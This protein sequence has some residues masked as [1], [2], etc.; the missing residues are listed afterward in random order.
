[1]LKRVIE[2][3][4]ISEHP[5]RYF[6]ARVLHFE[7]IDSTSAFLKEQAQYANQQSSQ[8]MGL[9]ALAEEQTA[10]YGRMGRHWHSP[11]GEGFYFSMLLTPPLV[12]NNA[13][14]L[15]LMAAVASA[16]AIVATGARALDIKWPNDILIGKRKIAGIIAEAS[17]EEQQ[18]NY[19]VLGIGV[20]LNQK[21]FPA[22]LDRRATSLYL[23]I[24]KRIEPAQFLAELLARIDH[25]YGVLISAPAGIAERWQHLSSFAQ[26]R[27]IQVEHQGQ[28]ICART[29]GLEPSGAL[30]AQTADG[31][32]LVLY[33]GEVT[34]WEE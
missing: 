18:L 26:G 15:T 27:L 7:T 16:E 2:P 25:W 24:H 28:H 3:K 29:C 22:E 33:G 30:R 17:F 1:M 9:C 12:A 5:L 13:P 10:G 31:Q 23:E 6:T 8:L 14:L 20:N 4:Q 11:R 19:V 21:Y 32:L 34:E